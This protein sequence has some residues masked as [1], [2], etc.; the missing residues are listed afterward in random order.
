MVKS[1]GII[2]KSYIDKKLR[3]FVTKSYLDRKLNASTQAV[4]SYLD[5]EF[6]KGFKDEL[7]EIKDEIVGEIK[8]MR[9]EFNTHQYSHRRINDEIQDHDKRLKKLEPSIDS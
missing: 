8:S 5:G 6:K 2:T 7:Y 1:N 3:S 4:K 9:E